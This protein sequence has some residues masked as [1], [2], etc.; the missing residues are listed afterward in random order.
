MERERKAIDPGLNRHS[1]DLM[2]HKWQ[3][4][5]SVQSVILTYQTIK[6]INLSVSPSARLSAHLVALNGSVSVSLAE[7]VCSRQGW[8]QFVLADSRV[9]LLPIAV[10]DTFLQRGWDPSNP[11]Q[12]INLVA[13][14]GA[15]CECVCSTSD[16]KN[17]LG[18]GKISKINSR[19]WCTSSYLFFYSWHIKCVSV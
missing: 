8:S 6:H 18:S 2:I 4:W 5:S 15:E 19:A 1:I 11:P 12:F 17:L 7:E 10:M 14:Q 13:C 9:I 16:L 3:R